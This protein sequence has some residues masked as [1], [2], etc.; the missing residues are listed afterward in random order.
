MSGDQ[1]GE[2]T[3]LVRYLLDARLM[4]TELLISLDLS[5][6][7]TTEKEFQVALEC[8]T[9]VVLRILARQVKYGLL[10]EPGSRVK[11]DQPKP[12][13][14]VSLARLRARVMVLAGEFTGTDRD[15][16]LASIVGIHKV[17]SL[18][19]AIGMANREQLLSIREL[20]EELKTA[21]GWINTAEKKKFAPNY[22]LPEAFRSDK[23]AV[24]M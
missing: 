1:S 8:Q 15:M 19:K 7:T 4:R 22:G 21:Q 18:T 3:E 16:I 14:V 11:A 13:P 2:D 24:P 20:A 17:G 10:D 9:S 12:E 5:R 23:V 6:L